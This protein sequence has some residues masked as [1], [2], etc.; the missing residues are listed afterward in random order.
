MYYTLTTKKDNVGYCW[1]KEALVCELDV[2][3]NYCVGKS[4]NVG[5]NNLFVKSV[6]L[7]LWLCYKWVLLSSCCLTD[8]VVIYWRF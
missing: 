2:S 4:Q 6:M 8:V 3:V 1:F 5:S 7:W